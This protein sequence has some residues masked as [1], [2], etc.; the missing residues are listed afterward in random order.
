MSYKAGDLRHPVTLE[1]PITKVNEKGRRITTWEYVTRVYAAKQDV[2][3]REFYAAHADHAEDVVT[4]IIRWRDDVAKTW[5]LV[6]HGVAYDILLVDH[7]GYRRDFMRL[8]CRAVQGEG[9]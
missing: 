2:S 6:H 1:E 3:G 8:R 5:R 9:G 7:L 4:F